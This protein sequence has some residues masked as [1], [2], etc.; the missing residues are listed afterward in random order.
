MVDGEV[1]EVTITALLGDTLLSSASWFLGNGPTSV[2]LYDSCLVELVHGQGISFLV[3]CARVLSGPPKGSGPKDSEMSIIP[4]F[5]PR[6]G[7]NSPTNI[8]WWYWI[9]CPDGR[10]FQLRSEGA[11]FLGKRMAK[12]L[13][14]AEVTRRLQ[15]GDLYVSL[16]SVGDVED[17]VAKS[18]TAYECLRELFMV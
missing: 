9:P 6:G 7:S 5:A 11:S 2:E 3:P 17:V 18:R 4:N 12:V 10:W 8:T 1:L 16:T 15:V 14:A 13:S